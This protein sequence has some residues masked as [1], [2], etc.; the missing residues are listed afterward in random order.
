[1]FR[2][3][4]GYDELKES[5]RGQTE[6]QKRETDRDVKGLSTGQVSANYIGVL[7]EMLLSCQGLGL[8][9]GCRGDGLNQIQTNKGMNKNMWMDGMKSW[10]EGWVDG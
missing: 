6:R 1:M 9:G 2:L 7:L 3:K 5:Q 4:N 10:K 8:A